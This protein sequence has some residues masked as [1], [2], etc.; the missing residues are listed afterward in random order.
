[1]V[2]IV[3][4]V[5]SHARKSILAIKITCSIKEFTSSSLFFKKKILSRYREKS[6]SIGHKP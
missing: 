5:V 2:S 1:M 4:E 6:R 3:S